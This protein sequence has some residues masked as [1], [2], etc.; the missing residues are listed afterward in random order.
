[1]S[2]EIKFACPPVVWFLRDDLHSHVNCLSINARI[3][4]CLMESDVIIPNS[5]NI[6]RNITI[7]LDPNK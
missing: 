2:N 5:L 1:M 7:A 4:V 3:K 6:K